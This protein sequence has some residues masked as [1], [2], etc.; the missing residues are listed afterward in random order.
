MDK[1]GGGLDSGRQGKSG[2]KLHVF[3]LVETTGF[4]DRSIQSKGRRRPVC[5]QNGKGE[6]EGHRAAAEVKSGVVWGVFWC[7][8]DFE[9]MAGY[10]HSGVWKRLDWRK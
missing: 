10:M 5:S 1:S 4:A 7:G 6:A 3:F 9:W 8:G 2:G